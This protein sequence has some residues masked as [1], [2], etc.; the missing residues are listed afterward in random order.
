MRQKFSSFLA[1]FIG[2]INVLLA[3]IFALTQQK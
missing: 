3:V 1:I 2:L